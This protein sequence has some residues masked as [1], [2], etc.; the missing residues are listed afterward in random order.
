MDNNEHVH[1]NIEKMYSTNFLKDYQIHSSNSTCTLTKD[2]ENVSQKENAYEQFNDPDEPYCQV[3][4]KSILRLKDSTK[5]LLS[6]LEEIQTKVHT[7]NNVLIQDIRFNNILKSDFRYHDERLTRESIPAAF[8][9]LK[10]HAQKLDAIYIKDEDNDCSIYKR[11]TRKCHCLNQPDYNDFII[12][13]NEDSKYNTNNF[14]EIIKNLRILKK[15]LYMGGINTKN[16]LMFLNEGLTDSELSEKVELTLGCVHA[17]ICNIFEDNS[18]VIAC[19]SWPCKYRYFGNCVTQN[20]AAGFLYKLAEVEEG[21]RYLNYTSKITN[22]IKKVLRKKSSYLE[23]DIIDSLNA[24]LSLLK[25]N[26][27]KDLAVTYYSKSIYEGVGTRTIKDLMRYRQRMTLDEIFMHLDILNKYS[28]FELGKS[29]LTLQLPTLLVIFKRMLME[30]D[31][32]EVNI[33]IINTLDNIVS[34]NII[35]PQKPEASKCWAVADTATEPVKMKNEV[36]QMPYKKPNL[37]KTYKPKFSLGV[38]PNKHRQLSTRNGWEPS[39]LNA[40]SRKINDLAKSMIIV[41]IEK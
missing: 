29:E 1:D 33:I 18:I 4:L 2:E 31:N 28:S 11:L 5:Q 14:G 8:E 23:I 40:R 9:K 20:L 26:F 7:N 13:F 21:R 16:A 38:L 35:K 24:T 37:K 25:P 15:F 32:S 36:C 22:D 10:N 6:L 39:L 30:Y 17:D 41:P 27:T 19:I 34:R 3:K 12:H